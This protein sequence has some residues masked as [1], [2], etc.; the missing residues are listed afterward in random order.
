MKKGGS[1]LSKTQRK[2]P[3]QPGV[4]QRVEMRG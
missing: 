3:E 1:G 4:E 2:K